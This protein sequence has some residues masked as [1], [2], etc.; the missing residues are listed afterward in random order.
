MRTR[1]EA[2][3]PAGV[4]AGVLDAGATRRAILRW[5]QPRDQDFPWRRD[6]TPYR[7]LVSEFMLQQTQ[8]ARVVPAFRAFMRRFPSAGS[9]AN[10]P[11]SDVLR[12]W[13]GLGYNRR[14]IALQDAA[15]VVTS[16]GGR[17]PREVEQLNRL[18]GVGAYTAAA[19]ASIAF[20]APV[21]ALDVNVRRVVGRLSIGSDD[22]AR[23][24]PDVVAA[25]AQRL[26]SRSH[27]GEWN[28]AVMDIGR[29]VC[30]PRAPLC[31]VCPLAHWCEFHRG[32]AAPSAPPRRQSP[33]IGSNRQ[34]RGAVVRVLTHA[35]GPTQLQNLA[36]ES[37]HSLDRIA[38]AVRSLASEGLITAG[39]A[40]TA[41]R[42]GGRV[43]LAR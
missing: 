9:L 5:Y 30:R 43:Q 16:Q 1:I 7:I 28:Q 22:A 39:P 29:E 3:A 27:P 4:L 24:I 33:F 11:R 12:A 10:A 36:R 20:G 6:V 38:E 41:G 35:D 32:G 37:G 21:A 34:V 31:E 25:E 40:A 19:V 18:P 26:V 42:P 15:R 2:G 13:S 23:A 14:A 17:F 8:A